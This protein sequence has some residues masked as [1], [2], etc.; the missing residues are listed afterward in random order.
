MR[1]SK[2]D[3]RDAVRSAKAAE[4]PK[5]HQTMEPTDAPPEPHPVRAKRL[6]S[7]DNW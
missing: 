5:P 3:L 6:L 1:S 2:T 7:I 4:A